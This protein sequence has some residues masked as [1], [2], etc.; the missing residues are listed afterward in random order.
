MNIPLAKPEILEADI[1]AVAAV[2]RSSRLSQGP[3]LH[4]FEAALAAYLGV[5]QAVAVNSGTSALQLALRALQVGDG[6]EVILPSFS[7]MAVTNAVLASGATP[8][9]ADINAK[10]LNLDAAKV[11]ALVSPRTKAIIVVHTFGYPAEVEQFV[12]LADRYGLFVIE[13]ACEAI[14]A[15]TNGRKAG[16]LGD[17]GIFAFYPNK[18]ITT[19][20]GGALVTNSKMLG[21]VVR[22]LSN[23]GRQS[24]TEWFQ[25]EDAGYSYRLSDI[26]CAL[27]LQQLS[28]IEEILKT[29]EH[30]ACLYREH[31]Q[32]ND[33]GGDVKCYCDRPNGRISWF[34]FP[35]LL[36]EGIRQSDRDEIWQQ[37]RELGIE[38]G[39]Y[40][41]PAHLQPVIRKFPFRCGD[42]SVTTDV[43]QRLL[44]LPFFNSLESS[45]IEFVCKSLHRLVD[46]WVTLIQPQ[47]AIA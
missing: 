33:R 32:G 30:L 4:A 46:D 1:S 19:G 43:A 29:R 31:L 2:L 44:C 11:E 17:A 10:T 25:H 7:F 9:Y 22:N 18:Q 14:G 27:G 45:S 26:N 5:E 24:T 12:S 20:E 15:E 8:V 42:L 35:V 6:D 37:L 39:R 34:T 3:A 38:S 16:T 36:P 47:N 21:Q 41:P 13:D 28:R 40:F 23:Q